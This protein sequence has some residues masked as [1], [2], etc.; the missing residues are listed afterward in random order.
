[1]VNPSGIQLDMINTISGNEDTSP[2]W[3]WDSAA[4]PTPTGYAVEI[5]LPLQMLRFKGGDEVR[6]GVLFWRR[7]SRTGVSVAWP[8]LQPGRWVFDT[9]APLIFKDLQARPSAK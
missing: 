8:A 1:M 4:R 6:M 2:D 9:H 5:R 7:V 3:V